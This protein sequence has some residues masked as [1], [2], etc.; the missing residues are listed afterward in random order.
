MKGAEQFCVELGVSDV[1]WSDTWSQ[2]ETACARAGVELT[3]EERMSLFEVHADA[4]SRE[5]A[6]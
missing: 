4:Y 6:A 1:E 2:I 5:S 3:P